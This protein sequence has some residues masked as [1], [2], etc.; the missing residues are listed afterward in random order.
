MRS[1]VHICS[2]ILNMRMTIRDIQVISQPGPLPVTR[3][4]ASAV[5]TQAQFNSAMTRTAL[6]CDCK[7]IGKNWQNLLVS[8]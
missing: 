4:S 6:S 1:P 8:E 7:K 2:F 5:R 3:N